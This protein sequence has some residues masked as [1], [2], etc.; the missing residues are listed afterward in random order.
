MWKL[1]SHARI[2]GKWTLCL[3]TL[4]IRNYYS[5]FVKFLPVKNKSKISVLIE[6][7]ENNLEKNKNRNRSCVKIVIFQ[8]IMVFFFSKYV[9]IILSYHFCS[10]YWNTVNLQGCVSFKCT[11]KWFRYIY[12]YIY[13]KINIYVLFQVIFHYR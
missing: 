4:N 13:I 9:F 10:F 3:V 6:F 8:V 12:I 5:S 7:L 1:W 2:L 11:A